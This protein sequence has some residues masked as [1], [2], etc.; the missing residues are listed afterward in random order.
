MPQ[1]DKPS[2]K[3]GLEGGA[4]FD[5][6]DHE[7]DLIAVLQG[8]I[9]IERRLNG[10]LLKAT[11]GA[12]PFLAKLSFFEKVDVARSSGLITSELKRATLWLGELRNRFAH[13]STA[14][15]V[16]DAAVAKARSTKDGRDYIEDMILYYKRDS[17]D[18][19]AIVRFAIVHIYT[20]MGWAIEELERRQQS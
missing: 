7:D 11:P 5:A 1:F 9:Y 18:V 16:E 20:E 10:L 6:I 13:Q 19:R 2:E 3:F 15:T 14:V 12:D 4:F 17:K 8:H